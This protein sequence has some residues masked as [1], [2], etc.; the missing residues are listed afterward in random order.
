MAVVYGAIANGGYIVTPH[1]GQRVEDNEGRALQEFEAPRRRKVEIDARY[2]QAIL[3]GLRQA[4]QGAGGTSTAV[5]EGFPVPIAGK[6][7]TAERGPGRPNQ[8]WYLSLAPAG[9]PQYVVATTFEGGGYGAETAAPAARKIWAAL[10][11][12]RDDQREAERADARS[13]AVE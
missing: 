4:A 12:V 7:G 13:G 1:L 8:S 6:T 2:R 9:N 10:Y 3:D 11:N 5:F